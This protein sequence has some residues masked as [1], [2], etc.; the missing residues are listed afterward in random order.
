MFPEGTRREK[1]LRKRH[2]ARW[3]S[4][5]ARIAL[6]AG[7]PLVPAGISGTDELLAPRPGSGSRS[8]T[9]SS[10]A[11][12]PA[13]RSTM[14]PARRPTGS[15]AAITRARG[16]AG[17]R[18]L[19]A[20]DGDSF[21][22]RAFHALPRSFRRDDGGPANALIGF[23]SM[24]LRLWQAERPRAVVVGWDTLF[25][26]TYR[27]ELL[28]DV[29]VRAR[30]RP[31]DRRPARA[32]AGPR[33]RHR[34]RLRQ[35][36]WLRGRRLPRRRRRG[37]AGARRQ[38]ARRHVRP[39][40]VPARSR[41]RHDP[42]ARARASASWRGSARPRC[43]SGTASTRAGVR[44]HRAARRPLRQDPGS[45]RRRAR[46]PPPRCSR[47]IPTSRRCSPPA[48]SRPKRSSCACS[49]GL[50]PSTRP[51]RCPTCRTSSPTGRPAPGQRRRSGVERLAARLREVESR[52]SP[53]AIRRWPTCTRPGTT[54]IRRRRSGCSAC[55]PP[56]D[57]SSRAGER[58]EPRSSARTTRLRRPDRGALGRVL[59][60]RRHDRPADHLGGGTA[61][62]RVRHPRGRGGRFRARPAAGP[63]RARRSGDGLLHLRQRG[64]RGPSR[65]G[66]ARHRAGRD[67]RLGRASR[68]RHR[69]DRARRR[70][71][72]VRLAPPVAVLPRHGRAGDGRRDHRQHPA[73]RPA[74]A[75]PSTPTRSAPSSS[76][77]CGRSSRGS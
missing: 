68:Q 33:R 60:R 31:R 25:V 56:S 64:R 1:G 40:R 7:V 44:L 50:R 5:A 17:V 69:G 36:R 24:L 43:G 74:P 22:H 65:A 51:R 32:P 63:P 42:A 57:P 39:R 73:A 2:E 67:R 14:P 3:R 29:P 62:R 23:M 28:A 59:A 27:N 45:A 19:L 76:R 20:V 16:V 18:P 30:V 13:C 61:R 26:P 53:S 41:R 37:R 8:A 70:L 15:S 9:R 6:E 52:W 55:S 48:G 66:G 34:H 49:A 72:P 58:R 77:P 21:A 75:T 12:S 35:A 38:H 10:S 4:G 47:R 71:D 11:I 46:R 54:T